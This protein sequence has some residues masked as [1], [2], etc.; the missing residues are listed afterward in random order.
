MKSVY[1]NYDIK[2]STLLKIAVAILTLMTIFVLGKVFG[3]D[4]YE[5]MDKQDDGGDKN[6]VEEQTDSE[7][8][9]DDGNFPLTSVNDFL[10]GNTDNTTEAKNSS[11]T[12][13]SEESEDSEPFIEGFSF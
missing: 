8:D 2:R 6:V 4:T 11:S 12:P 10:E 5:G 1:F 9:D 13:E 7:D 3:Y